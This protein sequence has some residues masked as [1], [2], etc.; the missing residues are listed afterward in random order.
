MALPSLAEQEAIGDY[1]DSTTDRAARMVSRARAQIALFREYRTR[2]IAD[3]VTGKL[4]VRKATTELPDTNAVAWKDG[5]DTIQ[6]ESHSHSAE[7][8]IAEG[9]NT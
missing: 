3:V 2:L 4:D 5:V 8:S 6:V 1:L 9:T 7:R